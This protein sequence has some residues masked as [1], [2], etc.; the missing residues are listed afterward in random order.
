M[1]KKFCRASDEQARKLGKTPN[2]CK[3]YRLTPEEEARLNYL[4]S[5]SGTQKQKD[6]LKRENVKSLGVPDDKL[7]TAINS[8]YY[9]DKSNKGFSFMVRNP[10]YQ[11]EGKDEFKAQ[12]L[13]EIKEYSP[14]FP[15]IE[16]SKIEE[17]HLLV[18]DIADLHINKYCEAY[19]TGYD[20]NSEVAVKRAIEGTKGIIK[21]AN[22]F[23][24]DKILF[25]TGNDVLNTDNLNKST[26]KGTPQDTDVN[27]Y[28]AFLMAKECY[29]KC[30]ELCLSVADV[31]VIH[32]P[33]NH[34]FMSGCFLSDTLESWFRN[35]ENITFDIT[36]KYRKYYKYHSNMIELE[37][38]DKGS[39]NK[40]PLTM[41]QEQPQM[42]AN[43]K[44][45]YGY[46]HHIHH[47]DKT[48]F[49][50]SKDSIGVNITYL[51]SPSPPD[52]WHSDNQYLNM[53][54]AEGFVHSK[55]HG[56]V[57]QITHYF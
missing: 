19:L 43:T 51:R 22:G 28:K 14:T 55:N 7:E 30:L 50:S 26:T 47:T 49:K 56:R 46:L 18:I 21:K 2:A 11:E 15:K 38:G 16:R 9:W 40:L 8:P 45:R 42:W 1:A 54:A 17:P 4:K 27:W 6:Y 31:D 57:S 41:A 23:D 13:K 36:P 12:I 39:L 5:Q 10:H 32:C 25:V 53:I 29:I 3:R 48:T 37:H 44:F 34:D 33:S 35:C 52:L 20:Y 24:I